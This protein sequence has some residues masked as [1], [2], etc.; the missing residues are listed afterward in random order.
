MVWTWATQGTQGSGLPGRCQCPSWKPSHPVL[1]MFIFYICPIIGLAQNGF[2]LN[3][4]VKTGPP[5]TEFCPRAHVHPSQPCLYSAVSINGDVKWGWPP[6]VNCWGGSQVC[7]LITHL[8]FISFPCHWEHC[9]S[10]G[11]GDWPSW[12]ETCPAR[13]ITRASESLFSREDA[14][15]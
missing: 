10:A 11:P 5:L 15:C 3:H 14:G 6:G 12:A 13:Q 4:C 7:H 2:P 9:T 1:Q 8:V